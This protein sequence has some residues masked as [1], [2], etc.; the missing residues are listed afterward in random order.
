MQPHQTLEEKHA[1]RK[2][3]QGPSTSF[4][5]RHRT[6]Q[7]CK[8]DV[9]RRNNI[10]GE[11]E[12]PFETPTPTSLSC[13]NVVALTGFANKSRGRHPHAQK[14]SYIYFSATPLMHERADRPINNPSRLKCAP[15]SSCSSLF[16]RHEVALPVSPRALE[17]RPSAEMGGLI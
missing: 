8:L 16:S 7:L 1:T 12:P 10:R 3:S 2:Y 6:S 13:S 4:T 17:R 9:S 15:N 11:P 14:T 5:T